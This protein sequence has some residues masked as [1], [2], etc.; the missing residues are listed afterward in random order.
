ML[1]LNTL[2]LVLTLVSVRPYDM[3]TDDNMRSCS[4]CRSTSSP[5]PRPALSRSSLS[6]T[7]FLVLRIVLLTILY[8][9]HCVTRL[10]AILVSRFLL[11]LQFANSEAVHLRSG[12]EDASGGGGMDSAHTTSSIN[13]GR[14]VGSIGST[15]LGSLPEDSDSD[16]KR[17]TDSCSTEIAGNQHCA[18]NGL[19]QGG[20]GG[21]PVPRVTRA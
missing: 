13:F 18:T 10:T 16:D 8:P 6:R 3:H 12:S 4:T 11:D 14:V 5:Q 20:V 19:E 2:H 17:S 21:F 15:I 7:S 9:P 1:V